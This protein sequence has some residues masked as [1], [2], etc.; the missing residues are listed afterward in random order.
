MNCYPYALIFKLFF[1]ALRSLAFRKR[2]ERMKNSNPVCASD[3]LH[4]PL[5]NKLAYSLNIF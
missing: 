1:S 5:F 4:F 3:L 2:M